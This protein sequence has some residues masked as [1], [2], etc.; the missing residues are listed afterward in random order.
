MHKVRVT[1]GK[2]DKLVSY[3]GS[4]N[5]S[6]LLIDNGIFIDRPCSGRGTCGKCKVKFLSEIPDANSFDKK[7]LSKKQ[8]A[9]GY[10]LSCKCKIN[11]DAHIEIEDKESTLSKKY[12]S[13]NKN[14][15]YYK[16]SSL[17]DFNGLAVDLGT[18]TIAA[19]L[20]CLRD[21]KVI[22][23]MSAINPQRKYGDNIITRSEYIRGNK[24]GLETLQSLAIG[25]INELIN[26]LCK[27]NNIHPESIA[28]AVISG[29]TIMQHIIM[30]ISPYPITVAPFTPVFT[31]QKTV[32]AE[33]LGLSILPDANCYI[34]NSISG[35]VGG[36]I[37]SGILYA[38]LHKKK[39]TQLLI[40]IGTNG[41]IV[42]S[43]IG[44]MYACSV[45]AG[46][47]FEGEH[48]KCGVGGVLGAISKAKNIDGKLK[49]STI[50]HKE[51]IGICG[52]G[53]LDIIAYLIDEKILDETGAL[54]EAKC[55]IIDDEPAFNITDEIYIFQKDIREI[56]LAKSAVAAGVEVLIQKANVKYKD[57]DR[58]YLAG[59]F[60]TYL[61]VKSA[62]KIGLI[63][64]KLR[65]K[66]KSIGN[67][68]GMG[69]VKALL[70][71]KALKSLSK[72]AGKVEYI[73]LSLDKSFNDLFVD[74]MMF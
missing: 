41:E 40:D 26:S 6:E 16:D 71:D 42:L 1:T 29:N 72:I 74:N 14:K 3:K 8:L 19:Y 48:I 47:A 30:G 35:Y 66:C 62:V 33:I 31:E 28:R 43:H 20:V 53:L 27:A 63:N 32:K 52:S 73:E 39:K 70:S 15:V 13:Q 36:D 65:K 18:T 5:L 55:T 61:N 57:I 44:K 49:F 58:V 68:S 46:P 17:K 54:D 60:G 45:A 12:K 38:K 24:H 51:P 67:S 10:R 21:G 11:I 9:D 25:K 69:S 37:V 64:K 22:D 7:T 4:A 34:A 56:Q 2:K 59:G 23:E 50:G